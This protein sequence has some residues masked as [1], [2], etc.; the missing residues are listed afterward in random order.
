MVIS[1]D[2]AHYSQSAIRQALQTPSAAM[3]T[4]TSPPSDRIPQL[5]I[6]ENT[7]GVWAFCMLSV[8]DPKS[9]QSSPIWSR[10]DKPHAA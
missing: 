7:T 4:A 1:H 8:K 9:A 3:E 5:Q 2:S 6:D 10:H